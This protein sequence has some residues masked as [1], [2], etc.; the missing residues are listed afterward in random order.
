M[1]AIIDL[2]TTGGKFNEEGIT[3]VA[4]YKFDG[5]EI[6]D[7]FISLVNPERP[8]QPFVVNLTG[9]TEKMVKTAPKFYEVAK[10][11]VEITAD[12]VF[13][14]HNTSFD[15][16]V[17]RTEFKR[18][19][20]DYVRETLCTVELSKNLI[21]DMPSY[22]LGKLCK[23]LGIPMS[24]RH[25]A[26]GD[27]LATVQLFKL[28]QSK[29]IGKEITKSSIKMILDSEKVVSNKILGFIENTPTT[30]G[31][32]YIHDANGTILYM[33]K[34][35]NIKKGINQLFLRTSKKIKSLQD[36]AFSISHE[37]TGNE[38]F[39]QLIFDMAFKK[40]KPRFNTHR[41]KNMETVVFNT[42][43]M[44]VVDRGRK[45]GEKSFLL[46]EDNNVLG[47][48]Y[49]SL[50]QQLQNIP[51]LKTLIT[52]T[53]NDLVTRYAVKKYLEKGKIERIIRY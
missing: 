48:G 8:I 22:S 52:K 3:E 20:F 11:I 43:N 25:R 41:R 31:V 29:D 33:G 12:C 53:G 17:L 28:L 10:R 30:S 19:G 4:I 42:D 46:V 21:P 9:I 38:L 34:S 35:R 51:L 40:H 1:Y 36:Q 23:S 7:Q 16:R 24:D 14:A 13:I 27:A 44:V 45:T 49:S 47:I 18:L 32:F 26:S 2:E 50:E 37:E 5:H 6:V 39:A 15:Y